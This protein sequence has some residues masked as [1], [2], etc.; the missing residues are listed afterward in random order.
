[1]VSTLFT[2]LP[3]FVL[4]YEGRREKFPPCIDDRGSVRSGHD[5]RSAPVGRE[6]AAEA[7]RNHEIPGRTGAQTT[8]RRQLQRF[9]KRP[10]RAGRHGVRE[11]RSASKRDLT[12]PEG[13]RDHRNGT[14]AHR[15]TGKHGTEQPTKERVED[16]CGDGNA[17][18]IVEK[19]PGEVLF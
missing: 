13:V 17:D 16:A 11:A 18:Q 3:S 15:R 2:G 19:S 5:E 4:M 12:K 10:S 1:M 9:G 14:E 6:L 8:L 7:W